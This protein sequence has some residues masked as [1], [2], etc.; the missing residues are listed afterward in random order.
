MLTRLLLEA[1][2]LLPVPP[3]KVVDHN[4][5]AKR[6]V[7]EILHA[8]K[9]KERSRACRELLRLATKVRGYALEAIACLRTFVGAN[10]DQTLS[11]R[12]LAAELE[13]MLSRFQQVLDQTQ[14]RVVQGK[15]CRLRTK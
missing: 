13:T 4:R 5:V 1:K 7:L 15:R 9:E 8:K 12:I 10:L 2:T 3:Y 14:R 11:A 6:R